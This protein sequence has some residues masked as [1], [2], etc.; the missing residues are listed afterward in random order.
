MTDVSEPSPKLKLHLKGPTPPVY[1]AVKVTI[2][3]STTGLGE[4]VKEESRRGGLENRMVKD[5]SGLTSL[6]PRK[7]R[8]VWPPETIMMCLTSASW[9]VRGSLKV[10]LL[11]PCCMKLVTS[12]GPRFAQV[13]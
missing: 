2:C 6:A 3:P 12:N 7:L 11:V 13:S 4:A 10:I 9:D 1:V 5:S 8:I